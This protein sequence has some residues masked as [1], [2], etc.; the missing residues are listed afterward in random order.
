MTHPNKRRGN[1]FERELV[2]MAKDLG[3]NAV[4]AYSSDGRSLGKSEKVDIMIENVTIQAKKRA[5]IAEYIKI[6]DD[7]DM[8][9]VR[10]NRGK[11]L[12]IVPFEK[13]L[14]LIKEG[15]WKN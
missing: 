14:I 15:V 9:V 12:A 11:P 13:I 2:N 4:R 5:K 1:T 10:E 8:V 6:P 7:V 3:L